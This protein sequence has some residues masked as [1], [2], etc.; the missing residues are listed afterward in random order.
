MTA[1]PVR[2]FSGDFDPLSALAARREPRWL[3]PAAGLAVALHVL[4]VV[5]LPRERRALTPPAPPILVDLVLPPAI[6]PPPV[7]L[8]PTPPAPP[9]P[10]TTPARPLRLEP[11]PR[12]AS[13]PPPPAAASAVVTRPSDDGPVD[14][15]DSFVTG[16]AATYVG[17]TPAAT[18]SSTLRGEPER[19]AD[20]A[21]PSRG[22]DGPPGRIDRSRR[23]ML[24]GGATWQ[25]P[26][27]SE[28]LGDEAT[29]LLR[30]QVDVSGAV[31]GVSVLRDPGNGFGR[32]AERCARSKSWSP[33][34]DREG[35]AVAGV[36]DVNVRFER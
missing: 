30:V 16:R 27:P 36:S 10:P 23:A 4:V 7:P 19:N 18:G 34:L 12:A 13:P 21:A 29:V 8:P 20:K 1:A 33:A 6:A 17:G 22:A 11:R 15:S 9:V 24:A 2:W 14:L 5:A 25:C 32:E 31:V 3:G 35:N 28:A 26:F